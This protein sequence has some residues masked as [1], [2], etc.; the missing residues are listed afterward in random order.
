M[1]QG[2][3]IWVEAQPLKA[4]SLTNRLDKKRH[5]V[6]NAAVW[7]VEGIKMELIQT[8]NTQSTSLLELKSH[9]LF[10][11]DIVEAERSEI[12]TAMLKDI[13]PNEHRPDFINLDIQGAELRALKGYGERIKEL[14][15][16]YTEVNKIELYKGCALVSE[17]DDF[18]GSFGFKRVNT[19]WWRNHGWGDALYIRSDYNSNFTLIQRLLQV[20]AASKWSINNFA[21]VCIRK[22]I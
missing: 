2:K 13:I 7:D 9:K 18:L 10:Y 14:N 15:W 5:L 22:I 11:P 6:I 3:I 20:Y 19:R 4:L 21:R 1:M 12:N 17:I 8:T 16:I